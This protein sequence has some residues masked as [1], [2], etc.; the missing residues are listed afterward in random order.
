MNLHKVRSLL[1]ILRIEVT[2]LQSFI[3]Y[4]YKY[5]YKVIQEE[6]PLFWEVDN[7]GHCDKKKFV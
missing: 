6:G 2:V 5:K 1:E 4:V 7:M 3:L